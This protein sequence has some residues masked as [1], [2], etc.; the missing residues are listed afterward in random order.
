VRKVVTI[1]GSQG[2]IGQYMVNFLKNRDF[3]VR[4]V[5]IL[6]A[7]SEDLRN[8]TG[9]WKSAFDGCDFV[10]FLAFDVGGSVYL[11]KYQ[12][13]FEFIQNNVLIMS[14]V[15]EVLKERRT[16]FLFASSQMS[17]MAFSTYGLLKALGER[18]TRALPQGR[19]VH[20]WN[21][22]GYE[23]EVAKFHV[24]SDF[25]HMA[26]KSGEISMRTDGSEVRDFLYA[27]DCAEG[28]YAI[29]RNFDEIDSDAPLHLAS[30]EFVSIGDIAKIV[31]D[32]LHATVIPGLRTDN[33]QKM[34]LNEPDSYMLQ[35]WKPRTS[36]S[37]GIKSIIQEVRS[38]LE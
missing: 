35:F 31:A 22:Y 10:Y 27:D 24:I 7:P 15:F 9:L 13:S 34:V 1:L 16:K 6:R 20:F 32:E 14:N 3:E 28:L 38:N 8:P 37:Q 18:W 25:I 33:V 30:H 21:V 11:E 19:I 17:S 36:L 29:Y 5:D 4:E 23:S 2:Q 26:L 12:D